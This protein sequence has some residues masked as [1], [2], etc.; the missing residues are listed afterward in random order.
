[1]ESWRQMLTEALQD[2]GET[3]DDVESHTLTQTQLDRLFDSGLGKTAG[4]PFTLWT[5][6]R[7]YFPACYDG[8]EWVDSVARHPDGIPTEHIGKG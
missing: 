4:A 3:W 8:A 1:M 6:A 2:H 5:R 7:V